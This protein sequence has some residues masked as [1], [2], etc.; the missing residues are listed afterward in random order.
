MA[1]NDRQMVNP[2]SQ[3]ILFCFTVD[4]DS[5]SFF[6][7]RFPKRDCGNKTIVGWEGLEKGKE[8]LSEIAD[9]LTDSYGN[10]LAITWFVRCDCQIKAQYGKCDHLLSRYNDWWK[11]R[12]EVGDEIQWHAHLYR[13][14]EGTWRQ[15]TDIRPLTKDLLEG[16]RAFEEFGVM[17]TVI[18]IGEAYHSN[19]LMLSLNK[20]GLRADSSALPGRKRSDDEKVFDWEST[21][22]HP[23]RPSRHDCRIPGTPGLGLWEIPMNTVPTQVSY[24]NAPLLRYINPAFHPNAYKNTE[25]TSF[26]SEHD[27]V[28]SVMHPFEILS[29]FFSDSEMNVHPLLSFDPRA[30]QNNMK[31]IIAVTHT[32]GKKIRFVTMSELLA[33]LDYDN[34]DA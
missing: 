2:K 8:L 20:I 15:E 32:I 33:L 19:E 12:I 28:V 7:D 4:T 26:L 11:G 22:N 6:G 13:F 5:D 34:G 17:P 9:V 31:T 10:H 24:D 16:K 27:V 29:E 18:R 23:Y 1:L 21:P 25:V 14:E 30:V 3:E